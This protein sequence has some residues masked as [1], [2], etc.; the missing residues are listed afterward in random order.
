MISMWNLLWIVP[1]AG[2]AGG[3]IMALLAAGRNSEKA[4]QRAIHVMMAQR[5]YISSLENTLEKLLDY[6]EEEYHG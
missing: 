2:S 5:R 3:M 1:L 6:W 4:L